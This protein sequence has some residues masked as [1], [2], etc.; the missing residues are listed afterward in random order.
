MSKFDIN[1]NIK[2][3]LKKIPDI[4]NLVM[5]PEK[6]NNKFDYSMTIEK[7]MYDTV[8]KNENSSDIK[9]T[10][11]SCAT[12]YFASKN[13]SELLSYVRSNCEKFTFDGTLNEKV[14]QAAEKLDELNP[15]MVGHTKYVLTGCNISGELENMSNYV[16]NSEFTGELFP[17]GIMDGIYVYV[18]GHLP[19]CN[20]EL[21]MCYGADITYEEHDIVL[22]RTIKTMDKNR[23]VVYKRGHVPADEETT[24]VV[25]YSGSWPAK[26]IMN[27]KCVKFEHV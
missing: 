1:I 11:I 17:V 14:K 20:H 24:K 8:R 26:F 15:D 18:D 19:Y 23:T 25:N 3:L 13:I 7:D 21:Y 9:D 4:F 10:V 16:S 6:L 27:H 2:E 5:S 22:H 12:S